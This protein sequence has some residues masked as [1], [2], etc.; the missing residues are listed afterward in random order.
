MQLE[1]KLVKELKKDKQWIFAMLSNVNRLAILI[2]LQ[3]EAGE[4]VI[5]LLMK[6]EEIEEAV[7]KAAKEA[8]GD[9]VKVS[10]VSVT[11]DGK[12]IRFL[13]ENRS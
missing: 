1:R 4:V 11:S 9:T 5:T 8:L 2:G 6:D 3:E 12:T 7:I 13:M 10:K